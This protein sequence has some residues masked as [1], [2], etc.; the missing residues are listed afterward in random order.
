MKF[1][2]HPIAFAVFSLSF[3]YCTHHPQTASAFTSIVTPKSWSQA[4]S[5]S[6]YFKTCPLFS[7]HQSRYTTEK[8]SDDL[9]QAGEE[10]EDRIL[11]TQAH[12]W[13][14]SEDALE[15]AKENLKQAEKDAKENLKTAREDM[16]KS[17]EDTKE[18]ASQ[19]RKNIVSF[20]KEIFVGFNKFVPR[21]LGFIARPFLFL[22]YAP[23]LLVR[24]FLD[25]KTKNEEQNSLQLAVNAANSTGNTVERDLRLDLPIS[26]KNET[27]RNK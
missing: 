9:R 18:R 14:A 19:S 13:E 25:N 5:K 4:V 15:N 20:F 3:Q 22:Y 8:A 11:E 6:V 21:I 16:E 23:S 17:Y 10:V 27:R 26:F 2:T 12:V 24:K 7:S 1:T